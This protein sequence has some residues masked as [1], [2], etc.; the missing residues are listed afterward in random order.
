MSELLFLL[1]MLKAVKTEPIPTPFPPSYKIEVEYK[2]NKKREFPIDKYFN[3]SGLDNGSVY[4][5]SHHYC[6]ICEFP[7][8]TLTTITLKLKRHDLFIVT[9]GQS[10]KIWDIKRR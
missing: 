8:D 3:L 1:W 5:V 7:L 2:P 9:D 10:W 4:T 6:T